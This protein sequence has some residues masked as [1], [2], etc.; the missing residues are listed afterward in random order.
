MRVIF[1]GT[2]EF[3]VPCLEQLGAAG[4]DVV[5]CVTQPDRPQGRG[6][7]PEPSPVKRAAIRLGLSVAQPE[8]LED[9]QFEGFDADV[10][11]AVAY[12]QLIPG[13][14][15]GLPRHGV[16]GVH[17][18]L[19]PKY[20]GAAPVAW[21]IL[22]GETV[23][24]VT[25]FR[26]TKR[27]DAGQILSRQV[28]PIAPGEIADVLTQRLAQVGAEELVRALTALADGRARFEPQ[29]ESQA[30]LAPKL[31]KAQGL[32]AWDQPAE[33]IERLVRATQPWPGASTTWRGHSLKIFTASVD[34]ATVLRG[35]AP[36]TVL[37]VSSEALRVATGQGTLAVREVQMAGKRR[38]NV[39]E[40]LAGHHI[41][42]GDC[43]GAGDR[44]QET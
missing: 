37:G 5:Q 30:S 18:S 24:G 28:T 42:V 34:T 8:R 21:A 4:H 32:I 20:R 12:G 11:V 39:K 31:T 3:A 36:G 29:D 33:A 25:I 2:S 26:L 44:R 17:P 15:L 40:F 14:F 23:T 22:N 43:F 16:L 10:G 35:T 6:L 38:M 1:F 9:G 27:L 13:E 19:L 41:E 7:A